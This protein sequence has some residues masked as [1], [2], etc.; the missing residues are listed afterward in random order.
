MRASREDAPLPEAELEKLRSRKVERCGEELHDPLF[1]DGYMI[2]LYW[3]NVAR[4]ISERA[5]RDARKL[6]VPLYCL[7]ASD[8]RGG[9]L[10]GKAQK[11]ATHS[12]LTVPNIH[13]TG[14]LH[15][16]LL[17]HVSTVPGSPVG[18]SFE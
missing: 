9:A 7:Q 16:M 13:K 4:S 15:G 17:L 2:G 12:L 18:V 6:N 8:K 10:K 1:A 14:K 3:E 11:Q 5:D